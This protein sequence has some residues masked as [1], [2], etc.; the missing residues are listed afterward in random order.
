M[1]DVGIS[2][3]DPSSQPFFSN[4]VVVR[5]QMGKL[6]GRSTAFARGKIVGNAELTQ[7]T[8]CG[9]LNVSKVCR[10]RVVTVGVVVE[11]VV[12]TVVNL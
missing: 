5:P 12:E 2:F 10:N 8:T 6:F 3:C 4:L 7:W 9:S 1:S 11:T